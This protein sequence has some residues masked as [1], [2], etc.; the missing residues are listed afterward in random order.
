MRKAE[1]INFFAHLFCQMRI[2][3]D[4][5]NFF[6]R[7]K[8]ELIE[9]S[10]PFHYLREFPPGLEAAIYYEFGKG[11]MGERGCPLTS[12][13]YSL[14]IQINEIRCRT[15]GIQ[16]RAEKKG[17]F[18]GPFG[19]YDPFADFSPPSLSEV[20]HAAEDYKTI[21]LRE[22]FSNRRAA[23]PAPPVRNPL[24]HVGRGGRRSMR[25]KPKRQKCQ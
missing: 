20:L 1:K 11:Q 15:A 8:D 5:T 13:G 16:W 9:K 7:L 18:V 6:L 19:E 14:R 24:L 23:S 25:K 3:Y 10:D 22:A 21:L 17:M 2:R 12:L 4:T